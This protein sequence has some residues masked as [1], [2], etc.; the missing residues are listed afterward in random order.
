MQL[1]HVGTLNLVL[2][3]PERISP[4]WGIWNSNDICSENESRVIWPLDVRIHNDW[5]RNHFKRNMFRKRA[6]ED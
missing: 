5:N 1:I 3:P 2:N 4:S 6:I